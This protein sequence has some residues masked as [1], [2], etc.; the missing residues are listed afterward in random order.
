MVS[1]IATK[2]PLCLHS[3][4]LN[5]N[6]NVVQPISLKTLFL[7]PLYSP[8][9]LTTLYPKIQAASKSQNSAIL[10]CSWKPQKGISK[11]FS[12]K[13]VFLLVGS[14]LFM[15]IR[16]KRVFSLPQPV[17]GS[18]VVETQE[19]DSEEEVMCM[20]LLEKNP[21]D[22]DVL[23]TIV[24]VKMRKGK[25]KE[26]LKYVEKL[27]E[28][29]PREM[30]W[31]LLEALC[32]EM[33]G[34]LSKA[35]RLFKEILKQ[36]PLL[37]RALHGL[38]MVM[39]KN[40]EGPTVFEMLNGALEVARQEKKVNEERNIKI[41][42]AQMHVVKGELEEALQKFKLLVQENPRDFRPYLCQGIVYS[43]LDKKKEADEQFEIYRSL[44]PKEF[45]QRGFLDDVVL[46]AKTETREQLEKE[47][48]NEFSYKT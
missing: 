7:P 32:Y 16:A 22:V 4:T 18:S 33:M 31:R 48:K 17:Q 8:K 45:P 41:L 6:S 20:K 25:T 47:F 21:K 19:G 27:I 30:E 26:A 23:K 2:I 44:V 24:N 35:K 34:Q 39:H 1:S 9:T 5:H 46:A 37:L 36:K 11:F 29:Q 12:E 28:V 38:A 15:G 13:F 10:T 43:L 3:S 42:V 40:F 14:F